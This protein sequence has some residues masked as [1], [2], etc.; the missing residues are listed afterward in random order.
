MAYTV[1]LIAGGVLCLL[2]V[3]FA[4]WVQSRQRQRM[5]EIESMEREDH[6]RGTSP[7]GRSS[8]ATPP[9]GSARRDPPKAKEVARLAEKADALWRQARADLVEGRLAEAFQAQSRAEY[10]IH[11]FLENHGTQPLPDGTELVNWHEARLEAFGDLVREQFEALLAR[12][13]GPEGEVRALRALF[14]RYREGDL[15]ARYRAAMETL[16]PKRIRQAENWIRLEIDPPESHYALAV[17]RALTLD[18]KR[19]GG[20]V[21]VHGPPANSEEGSATWLTLSARIQEKQATYQLQNRPV[22]S[23]LLP[24]FV[25]VTFRVRKRYDAPTTWD[26]LPPVRVQAELPESLLV[27]VDKINAEAAAR[28]AE[29][30]DQLAESLNAALTKLPLLAFYPEADPASFAFTQADGSLDM[31]GARALGY[32]DP[33]RFEKELQAFLP[34][35]GGRDLH[36][37]TELILEHESPAGGAWLLTV[38][39]GEDKRARQWVVRALR[40]KP[41]FQDYQPILALLTQE[42]DPYL[43]SQ[44]IQ[45]LE[46]HLDH[47]AV[48]AVVLERARDG[49]D[50]NAGRYVELLL[51]GLPSDQMEEAITLI[52]LDAPKDPE[53]ARG[54]RNALVAAIQALRH[55]DP[56][57]AQAWIRGHYAKAPASVQPLLA[58]YVEFPR[59]GAD[60]AGV[61]ILA[62]MATRDDADARR[63]ALETLA[64]SAVRTPDGWDA[65]AAGLDRLRQED[66]ERNAG[67]VSR[68]RRTLYATVHEA[69]SEKAIAV[70]SAALR[71][72]PAEDAASALHWAVQ[73]KTPKRDLWPVLHARA[74]RED[75]SEAFMEDV[76]RALRRGH[77]AGGVTEFDN[78]DLEA[79]IRAGVTHPSQ[80]VQFHGHGLLLAV[81][82]RHDPEGYRVLLE[83]AHAK[84]ATPEYKQRV[85]ELQDYMAKQDEKKG[86]K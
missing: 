62:D 3:T 53:R 30:R 37:I 41:W 42:E 5:A 44:V 12:M 33:A 47:E 84:A 8:R 21:L 43:R 72:D 54:A 82:R 31:E 56:E 36:R 27:H 80:K 69:Q 35:A 45:V 40:E 59:E 58:R 73:Q 50:P 79:V 38:L 9:P 4:Y 22:A 81:V 78:P 63:H 68:Y 10:M 28:R 20:K 39:T 77:S 52:P 1:R 70:W 17:E 24:K 14:H 34:T 64:R 23:L 7:T 65:V 6:A 11:R 61:A 15:E 49:E 29:V 2:V 51:R 55:R 60:K 66:S 48:K 75:F 67:L 85:R 32:L 76:M 83:E 16:A 13:A 71:D 25:E 57:R 18:A 19:A 86:K 46:K 26:D 74:M